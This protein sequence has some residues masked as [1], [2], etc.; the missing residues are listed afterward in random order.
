MAYKLQLKRGSSGSLPTGSAGEP[1]FTTDT[2]DL[3]I[4][5]GASNQ[6]FQKFIA[7][8]TSSQ[9]LKGDGSLDSG[10][11]QPLLNGTGFVK[12]SGTTIT[13][14]NS[15]YYLAS[16]PNSYITLSA[17]SATTPLNYNNTSGAFTIAQSS[18][19]AN[20]YLSSTDWT[21][22]NNKQNAL[23]NPVTGTGTTNYL[24]KWTSGS[25]IGNSNLIND[26]SGNLGL[27]V[28]PSAWGSN[29]KA[30]ELSNGVYLTALSSST[31]PIMIL[32]ANAYFDNTNFIYKN[33]AA[34]TRYQQDSGVHYWYNAPSGTA[35]NAITFT[36]AMTLNASGN[37][38]IGNTNDTYKLD[39]SGTLRA[40]GA[41]TFSSSVTTGG[42][43]VNSYG[44]LTNTASKFNLDFYSGNT[45]FYSLGS[46][47]STKGGFEFHTNSSD[48]SLDVIALK[49][50][51]DG[52]VGIGT[53]SPS[54]LLD[55]NRSSLGAI[56]QFIT[57]DGT[58]NPRLLINGT[59]EGVQ[60]FATYSTLA[61]NLM[62]GTGGVERVRITAGGNVGIGTTVV[63]A[64]LTVAGTTDL[65]WSASTSKL[66]ISR[67]GTVARLQNYENGSA[68]NISLAWDGG[69]VGIGTT[70]PTEKLEVNGNIKAS[71]LYS[72]TY[73]PTLA[74]VYNVTSFTAYQLQYMRV[75]NVVTVSGYLQASATAANTWTRISI[76]LPISSTFDFS[77]RAGGGGGGSATNNVCAIQAGAFGTSVVYLD[78][79]PNTTST[80]GYSFS[81]TYLIM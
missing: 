40:T 59:A 78:S 47:S 32:G 43:C 66:Q 18:G 12:A 26:A 53:T 25:A 54:Y 8:G 64:P 52:N 51:S 28:T 44:A 6:K 75:G 30:L 17:L 10:T 24:P 2:N 76:T 70:S 46:N 58:Y 48:G 74:A 49:I 19:S 71:N 55:V 67:S 37:L 13:Y 5:T 4:G 60:L 21:T 65:A 41:A 69:N 63:T 11:Y 61:D 35:G 3:Y 68:A 77:Y 80:L 20:G 15:T 29:W 38:S 81:F 23:T 45:R 73:T 9:F 1:L 57:N 27:G 14:D 22:F 62:L 16:N 39:V 72:G 42:L 34:A 50:G 7:S 36:Q 56:A 31:V 79:Y 33:S